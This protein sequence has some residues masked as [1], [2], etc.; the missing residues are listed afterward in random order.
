MAK[1]LLLT[2]DHPSKNIGG[3]STYTADI[4]KVFAALEVDYDLFVWNDLRDVKKVNLNKYDLFFNIQF[5]PM[6]YLKG[7][8]VIN[9][10]HGSELFPYS[11]NLV[12]K[13]FKKIFFHRWIKALEQSH[14]N[15]FISESTLNI[16]KN[17]G[18][19][20]DYSRDL[21]FYNCL[22]LNKSTFIEKSWNEKLILC[23]FA[24]DV[25]HKNLSG[26]VEVFKKIK[27]L[28]PKGAELYITSDRFNGID[29]T[30]DISGVSD[31]AREEILKKSHLNLLLSLDHSSRG[32]IE[33]F[34][35]TVLEAGKYGVPTI[36]SWYG[37][38]SESVRHKVTGWNLDLE[39]ELDI[40]KCYEYFQKNYTDIRKHTF[41]SVKASHSLANYEILLRRII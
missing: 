16:F 1:V 8:K 11:P 23:C 7:R 22:D 18:G 6:I 27:S 29:G 14:F 32:Q 2:P 41:D 31:E 36:S 20:V 17:V 26:V 19:K 21:V 35:L 13:T 30:R 40:K 28:H 4:E 9:V 10:L 34:G 39:D 33:G 24:R 38:L 15:I 37:G 3:L 25:P 12:K 5:F